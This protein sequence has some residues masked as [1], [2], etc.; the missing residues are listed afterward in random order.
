MQSPLRF[1]RALAGLISL[2]CAGCQTAHYDLYGAQVRGLKG[3]DSRE[4]TCDQLQLDA[5][6]LRSEMDR[7]ATLFPG[8][9]HP[10]EVA[11]ALAVLLTCPI[12]PGCWLYVPPYLIS[13]NI[14]KAIKLD[15]YQRRLANH[16]VAMREIGCPDE[17]PSTATMIRG[18]A[19]TQSATAEATRSPAVEPASG[20]APV[21]RFDGPARW[22]PEWPT[23]LFGTPP[24]SDGVVGRLVVFA[25][26]SVVF[27]ER[28]GTAN[29]E[30]PYKVAREAIIHV[31][32]TQPS[33]AMLRADGS[34]ERFAAL[35]ADG[36][37]DDRD[38]ARVC[39]MVRDPGGALPH[40][41]DVAPSNRAR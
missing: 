29:V 27:F 11:L 39:H 38:T 32:C 35:T 36:V 37:T 12:N 28:V 20:V 33:F 18:G 26:G 19:P 14:E 8:A 2:A 22:N 13:W 21:A 7:L 5:S 17:R 31:Q 23:G 10:G 6:N 9:T 41:P 40:A 1:R 3:V 25:D 16:Q 4:L 15:E 34:R 24:P 30:V